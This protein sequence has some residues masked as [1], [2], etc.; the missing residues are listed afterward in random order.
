MIYQPVQAG[1]QLQL[2]LNPCFSQC[3]N[4]KGA[5]DAAGHNKVHQLAANSSLNKGL[6]L[7]CRSRSHAQQ[8]CR[9]HLKGLAHEHIQDIHLQHGAAQSAI[10]DGGRPGL[11]RSCHCLRGLTPDAVQG[12]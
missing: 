3:I 5:N 1:T 6:V 7:A 4:G 9:A 12:C 2:H 11:Q 10:D 8:H